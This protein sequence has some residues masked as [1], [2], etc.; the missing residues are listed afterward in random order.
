MDIENLFYL[1]SYNSN[2]I[3]VFYQYLNDDTNFNIITVDELK[4]NYTFLLGCELTNK[5]AF[6]IFNTN[7]DELTIDR[8]NRICLNNFSDLIILRKLKQKII[9][10]SEYEPIFSSA[11][12]YLHYDIINRAPSLEIT[13]ILELNK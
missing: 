6:E 12:I 4:S 11:K 5:T 2:F 13:F 10:E 3:D 1:Y 8:M 7:V 9:N